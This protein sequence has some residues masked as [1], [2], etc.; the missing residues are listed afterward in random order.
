MKTFRIGRVPDSNDLVLPSP[1][2]SSKHA[3]IVIDD[4]NRMTFTDHSTNG[5]YINNQLLSHN[6]CEVTVNDKIVFPDG[7][8]LDWNLVL[9]TAATSYNPTGMGTPTMGMPSPGM[10][11]SNMETQGFGT[12]GMGSPGMGNPGYNMPETGGSETSGSFRL[13]S[14]S[15]TFGEAFKFGGKNILSVIGIYLLWILTYWIPYINVGTTIAIT[16]LPLK[17]AEGTTINPLYI[18]ESKYRK[19][20]GEFLL[21][22]ILTLITIYM[23]TI[24]L[25]FPA[26]VLTLSWSLTFYYL[27]DAKMSPTDALHASN[28]ATYGSKWT[29]F[30]V[31]LVFGLIFGFII[32]LFL[33]FL[34][35][36]AQAGSTG[37]VIVLILLM[38]IL[39]IGIGAIA[40]GISASV[41]L[42]L[43]DNVAHK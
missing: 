14:F 35:A 16:M 37:G 19:C 11:Y 38:I 10:G 20:M 39:L 1:V 25:F 4:Y 23:A 2:I 40:N 17:M 21:T 41:W 36:A 5:T 27:L 9:G 12:P 28:E 3:E 32:A 42:Q 30:L 26:I 34:V 8:V 22:R 33:F 24:F 31:R 43:R 29:L 13:L 7:S 18:F 15:Q 6:S